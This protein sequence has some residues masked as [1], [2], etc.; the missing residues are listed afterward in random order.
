MFDRFL[1][2]AKEIK[3]QGITKNELMMIVDLLNSTMIGSS[4]EIAAM[5]LIGELHYIADNEDVERYFHKWHLDKMT[6]VAKMKGLSTDALAALAVWAKRI[7]WVLND[8]EGDREE[9]YRI[10]INF[11]NQGDQEQIETIRRCVEEKAL[12]GALDKN[13]SLA[14]E[15]ESRKRVKEPSF[16][17]DFI[18]D[19]IE[20]MSAEEKFEYWAALNPPA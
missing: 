14:R 17:S 3:L 2:A 18:N 20:G 9:N 8:A 15:K 12:N 13:S 19:Y 1:K 5:T 4:D 11:F 7:F 6:S 10:G 16:E